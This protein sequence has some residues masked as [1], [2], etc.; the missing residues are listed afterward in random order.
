VPRHRHGVA[1]RDILPARLRHKSAA[2]RVRPK[3]SLEADERRAALHDKRNGLRRPGFGNGGSP[4][5]SS[6]YW[7]RD[8]VG[9]REPGGEG[10]G[11]LVRNGFL[12]MIVLLGAR[13]IGL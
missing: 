12:G 1:E 11:R 2:Q 6:E 5:D 13:L 9:G 4:A 7:P 8:N 3:I 10:I